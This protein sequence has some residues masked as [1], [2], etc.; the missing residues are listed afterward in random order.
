MMRKLAI[1]ALVLILIVVA[2]VLIVPHLIDI[3]LYRAQIQE[4]LQKRLGRPVTLGEMSL[5]LFPLSFQVQNA[6]IAE[7]PRFTSSQPFARVEKLA[8]SVKLLPLLHKQV[9]IT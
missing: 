4:Q 9:E 2:G 5:S 3:N 6:V 7:D 8:V 1:T